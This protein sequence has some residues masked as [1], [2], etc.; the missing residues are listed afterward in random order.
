MNALSHT[1]FCIHLSLG[2]EKIAY[3]NVL[4]FVLLMVVRAKLLTVLSNAKEGTFLRRNLLLA[5]GNV[6]LFMAVS[7]FT[8]FEEDFNVAGGTLKGMCVMMFLEGA[9]FVHDALFRPRPVKSTIT[10]K[11]LVS[12]ELVAKLRAMHARSRRSEPELQNTGLDL[13]EREIRDNLAAGVVEPTVSK[14]KSLQLAT[15]VASDRQ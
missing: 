14:I 10:N 13:V 3:V 7:T 11:R 6:D 5:F 9:V 15:E 4:G 12:S 8:R 1:C 2:F